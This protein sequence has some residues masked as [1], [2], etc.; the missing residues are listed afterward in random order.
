MGK[1]DLIQKGKFCLLLIKKVSGKGGKVGKEQ[2]DEDKNSKGKK[3]G[4]QRDFKKTE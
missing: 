3:R 2:E 1:M 4:K